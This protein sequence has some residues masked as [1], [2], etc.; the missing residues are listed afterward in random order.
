MK[1]KSSGMTTSTQL[2]TIIRVPHRTL[3]G[4]RAPG[5]IY[6]HDRG[7]AAERVPAR[8]RR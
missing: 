2:V 6:L 3:R 7:D 4:S 8:P 1:A 5:G